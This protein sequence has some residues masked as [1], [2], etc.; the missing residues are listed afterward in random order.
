MET[1][2]LTISKRKEFVEMKRKQRST[3]NGNRKNIESCKKQRKIKKIEQLLKDDEIKMLATTLVTIRKQM[4]SLLQKY[5]ENNVD[6]YILDEIADEE[7]EN[8][9]SKLT[10][11]DIEEE[12][13]LPTSAIDECKAAIEKKLEDS[14]D[15]KKL[16]GLKK[17]SFSNW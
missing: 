8:D 14:T 11:E 1:R 5:E 7:K 17:L 9:F 16:P 4:H 3:P 13:D 12:E 2:G 6:M 10:M 15:V